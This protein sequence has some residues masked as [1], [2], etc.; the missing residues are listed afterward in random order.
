MVP[1]ENPTD[2]HRVPQEKEKKTEKRKKKN[3][4]ER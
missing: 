4:R 3:T 2:T 1:D